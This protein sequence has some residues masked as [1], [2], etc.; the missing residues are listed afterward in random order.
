MKK[1]IIGIGGKKRHGKDTFA[2]M[3]AEALPGQTRRLAFADPLKDEVAAAT[4]HT[5][6]FIEQHKPNFR[7]IL[8]AWGTEFRRALFGDD[9]WLCRM[10]DAIQK[11]VSPV[12]LITDVRFPNEH[13]FVKERGGILVR[14]FRPDVLHTT[15]VSTQHASETALDLHVWDEVFCNLSLESLRDHAN[16]F[17]MMQ[18]EPRLKCGV[19]SAEC[20]MGAT[21]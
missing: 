20:G 2:T 16:E 5:R 3:L 6:E 11:S 12:I 14:I 1:I 7:L 13:A 19:R 18:I 4:G 8:Q 15:D 10:S 21:V 9:Y 17:S